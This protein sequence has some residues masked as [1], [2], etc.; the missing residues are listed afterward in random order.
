MFIKEKLKNSGMFD[1]D[2]FTILDLNKGSVFANY[3]K[4]NHTSN[5]HFT[6]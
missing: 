4:I 1:I 3:I 2:M 5:R 6:N